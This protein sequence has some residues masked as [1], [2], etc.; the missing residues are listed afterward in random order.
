MS[1][2]ALSGFRITVLLIISAIMI[3]TGIEFYNHRNFKEGTVA[4]PSVTSVKKLSDYSSIM[5]GSVNDTNVYIID[6]G[7]PGGT[8]LILG[9]TH[10]EEPSANLAA[11]L[12]MGNVKIDSGKIMIVLRSNKSASL[13]T[14]PG[15][16][17]PLYYNIKTDWGS[18]KYRMGDRW[19]S[20]LDSWPDP[21][22]YVNYPSG[23]LLAYMDIRNF[24]RTWPGRLDGLITEKTSAAFIELIKKENVDIFI[25]YHEAELEY[26]VIS[27]IVAHQKG[28]D[29]AAMSSMMLTAT[30]FKI[31]MEFSPPSLHG[32]SHREVG[33]FSDAVSLLFETPEPFLDRVRGKTNEAL[34]L[35]GKDEFVMRAGEAGL[36]Y[37]QIDEN[38]WHIDT[39][40]ARQVASTQMVLDTWS[41]FNPDKEVRMTSLPTYSEIRENGVGSYLLNPSDYDKNLIYYE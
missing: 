5:K 24:N 28:S 18:K 26:P 38:G 33:D 29:I 23:Q 27:T 32:L 11:E 35:E 34:L 19:S 14:R 39:R 21:E 36:L 2:K 8:A 1:E 4:G 25:D 7:K 9:G 40:V 15:D 41:D 30:E 17:Y 31:G 10:P 37:E 3:A 12:I 6:S 13:V 22:V 20:P 16:A